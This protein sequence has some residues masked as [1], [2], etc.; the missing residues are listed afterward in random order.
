[1]RTSLI[2]EHAGGGHAS[3][4]GDGLGRG[5]GHGS[6]GGVL[7]PHGSHTETTP[8]KVLERPTRTGMTIM[9]GFEIILDCHQSQ[10]ARSVDSFAQ[11]CSRSL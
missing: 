3:R 11:Q 9:L 4:D 6:K 1:M 2:I 7:L 8:G 10:S 5:S